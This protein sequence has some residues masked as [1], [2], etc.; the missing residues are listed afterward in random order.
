VDTDLFTLQ[1][2]KEEF[3]LTASRLVPYKRI[4][5]TIEAF[6][7]MPNR[8]LVVIGEGPEM[9]KFKA[10]ATPNIRLLGYQT[11]DRLRQYMQR[12]RAFVFAA[13]ED[14]G[15]TP[16]EAQA[17]GTPVIAYGRGGVT[18]TIIHGRTGLLFKEQTAAALI[19]AV[20]D[21]EG[22]QWDP[23]AIRE[24]AERFSIR[25]FREKFSAVTK[26]E[27]TEFLLQRI[28]NNRSCMFGLSDMDIPDLAT[29]ASETTAPAV[30]VTAM[31]DADLAA[32]E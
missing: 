3:Y 13:E 14:F 4:D 28:E 9:E 12:A 11:P 19:E 8:R 23:K 31:P 29:P 16:V 1:E 7:Q 32:A 27:W 21:F 15:I 20:E 30:P 18:E 10:I 2:E 6:R 22:R 24:N 5:L 17:C 25:Q 26:K